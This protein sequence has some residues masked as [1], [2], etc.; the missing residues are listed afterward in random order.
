MHK[1]DP[2]SGDIISIKLLEFAV[3]IINYVIATHVIFSNGSLLS[4]INLYPV[5]L[6]W[7]GSV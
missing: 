6:N 4:R 7:E 3:I 5:L 2:S 1:N